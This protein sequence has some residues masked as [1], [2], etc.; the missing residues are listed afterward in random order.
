LQEVGPVHAQRIALALAN[1]YP[2][3][4]FYPGLPFQG[5]GLLSRYPLIEQRSLMLLPDSFYCLRA[6]LDVDSTPVVLYVAHPRPPGVFPFPF[7]HEPRDTEIAILREDYLRKE[8]GP[9][10]VVGDFNM[11]DQSDA[12][13]ALDDLLSDSFREVGRGMGFTYPSRLADW[14]FLRLVRI[15]YLWH[16]AQFAVQKIRVGDDSGTSDHRPVIARLIVT[17]SAE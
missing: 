10:L 16:N 4:V 9:L 1:E 3:Q 15:D 12:Y 14:S 5:I 2:V 7:N 8:T 11:S 13:R 17:E 6:V